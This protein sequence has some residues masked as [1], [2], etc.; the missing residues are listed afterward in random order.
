VTVFNSARIKNPFG[1]VDVAKI[2]PKCGARE[3]ADKPFIASFCADCYAETRSLASLPKSIVVRRCPK[4]GRARVGDE[5]RDATDE[6]IVARELRSKH[7]IV[8]A[9]AKIDAEGKRATAAAV[10]EVEGQR[11]P[12]RAS[13]RFETQRQQ[14]EEC[15]LRASGY[16]EAVIQ[17]RGDGSDA[18]NKKIEKLAR[19]LA[20]R[21]ERDSFLSGVKEQKFGLDLLVGGKRAA[22]DALNALGLDFTT[23][24]KV[25]GVTRD[26][27]RAVRA[28]MLVRI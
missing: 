28:T 13:A 18:A 5:W 4:C 9:E 3:S 27:K 25:L 17:L 19:Q 20:R 14:C 22:I 11:V 26:G 2:C 24:Y 6:E 15:A 16:H 7:E 23:E 12:A 21:V 1:E 10:V 8:S